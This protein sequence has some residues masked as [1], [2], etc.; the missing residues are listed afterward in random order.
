MFS[1]LFN[2]PSESSSMNCTYPPIT[3][4]SKQSTHGRRKPITRNSLKRPPLF[5]LRASEPSLRL[6]H[7]CR[8][9]GSLHSRKEVVAKMVKEKS[10]DGASND[11]RADWKDIK[12]LQAFCEF[13][14]VQVLEGQR[15]G[16]FLTKIGVDAV[17]QQLD[18]HFGKVVTFLQ[19]KNKWDHMK[20]G[21]RQYNECF[22]NE[23][24]LGYDTGTGLLQATDEWW[25]RKIVACP[26]AKTFK[27]KRLPNRESLNIMYGGT[28]AT[29]KNAFCTSRQMPKETT[30]GSGDSADSTQ[31]VDPQCEPFLNVDAMEVEGPSSSR[32][33]PTVT[34]GKG[35]ATSVHLFKPIC[36]KKKKRLV[37]QEMSDSL[38]S[39][40]EVFL[41]SRSVGTCTPFA[42]NT[43]TQVKTILDMVLSFPGMHSGHYLHLFSTV[44]FM[45]KEKGRHMFAALCD[46]K[47]VQLKWLQ[48][49]YQRHLEFHF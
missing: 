17:I 29:G 35:L 32:A 44:Y 10:K 41:E 37:A 13:C 9:C 20:K 30:K 1:N 42:S 7:R 25:T 5:F 27:N 2:A 15:S 28:V 36:K 39:I 8:H 31:F 48:N 6:G 24:R 26:N 49:E 16:G 21:W 43:T 12:E 47:D 46:D 19:I 3:K 14:A 33:G 22:D 40:S 34:K 45:E 11:P 18:N 38:K 4:P 23:S